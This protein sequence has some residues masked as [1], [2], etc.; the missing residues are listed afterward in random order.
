[1]NKPK[2][3]LSILLLCLLLFT[4]AA[5]TQQPAEN[6][7]SGTNDSQPKTTVK[8]AALN[9]PTGMGLVNLMTK[10]DNRTA[11]NNYEFTMSSAPDQVSASV[12]KGEPDLAAVPVNLAAT[13]YQKTNGQYVVCAINTLGVLYML[14]TTDTIH[15]VADLKGQTIYATGQ[16]STPEYILRYVLSANGIDPDK[17]VTIEFKADHAELATLVKSGQ[18]PIAM[19]PEPNVTSAIMGTDNVKIALNMTEEWDK[20]STDGSTVVQGCILV[21]KSFLEQN[22]TA[23]DQFM[24]DYRE[25]VDFVTT[26][27]DQA[28]QA[29]AQ[30]E[31]VPKAEIAQKAIPNC[32]IALITGEEMKTKLKPFLEILYQYNNASVGGSLPDDNFY[33]TA[34]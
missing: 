10:Q 21:K 25:S 32:N 1:M 26:N 29:I 17:D 19:L 9:G 7:D 34:Q 3:I 23:Y 8:I 20:V 28:A 6:T 5:C 22:Q 33:Y 27:I 18:A 13:L 24:E 12:I 31:I 15:S 14:D 11:E 16:G 4:T 2:K 30:Y